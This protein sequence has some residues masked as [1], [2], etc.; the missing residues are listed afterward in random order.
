MELLTLNGVE[1]L[2]WDGRESWL[3][4]GASLG[5]DA[6]AVADAVVAARS[7]DYWPRLFADPRLR[8]PAG[9]TSCTSCPGGRR[10]TSPVR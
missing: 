3:R 2:P 10:V 5:E 9:I 6:L 7:P 4:K 1:L 8:A